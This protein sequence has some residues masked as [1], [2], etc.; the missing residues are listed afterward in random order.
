MCPTFTISQALFWSVHHTF[1]FLVLSWPSAACR[2]TQYR[3]HCT[4]CMVHVHSI[5]GGC[6]YC[7]HVMGTGCNHANLHNDSPD[8]TG[9]GNAS[10]HNSKYLYFMFNINKKYQ[11]DLGLHLGSMLVFSNYKIII[12]LYT[13]T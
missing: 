10:L 9:L 13:S 11:I 12:L 1:C 5:F 4:L 6:T 8:S 3:C 7:A 2:A